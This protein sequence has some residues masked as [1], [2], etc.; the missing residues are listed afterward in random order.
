MSSRNKFSPDLAPAKG[1]KYVRG[2]IRAFFVAQT[3]IY[4]NI[5]VKGKEYAFR[6]NNMNIAPYLQLGLDLV[7]FNGYCQQK[8][9][10]E[11]IITDGKFGRAS[12]EIN[13]DRYYKKNTITGKIISVFQRHTS[14]QLSLFIFQEP[15]IINYNFIITQNEKELLLKLKSSKGRIIRLN[16]DDNNKRIKSIEVFP[17]NHFLYVIHEILSGNLERISLFNFV[18]LKQFMLVEKVYSILEELIFQNETKISKTDITELKN[19]L[20]EKLYVDPTVVPYILLTKED[21]L[22]LY[23]D[24]LI[25][26]VKSLLE[27]EEIQNN[28]TFVLK[29]IKYFLPNFNTKK[30]YA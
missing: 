20:Y 2:E 19:I 16:L 24:T 4:G 23:F 7:I 21:E 18:V 13:M 1:F 15:F 12:L 5:L 17:K 28:K 10:G 25:T 9:G 27:I 29:Y 11:L 26:A 6:L 30:W 3:C 22:W 8:R 14:I